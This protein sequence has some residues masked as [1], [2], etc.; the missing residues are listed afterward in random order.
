MEEYPQTIDRTVEELTELHNNL[1]DILRTHEKIIANR[2]EN[3][4]SL[5]PILDRSNTERTTLRLLPEHEQFGDHL[6]STPIINS[7][8][9]AFGYAIAFAASNV[10]E[11]ISFITETQ[12][13]AIVGDFS[14]T[15]ATSHPPEESP[16]GDSENITEDSPAAPSA[17][18]SASEPT[19]SSEDFPS[20]SPDEDDAYD[21]FLREK[22]QKRS[23]E[24]EQNPHPDQPP[25]GD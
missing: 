4:D 17:E 19:S 9:I 7:R 16:P 3:A 8:E 20:D 18:S 25:F 10:Q 5:T 22:E 6:K 15:D 24:I 11:F 21:R 23:G 13:N 12:M 1:V 2:E 14:P